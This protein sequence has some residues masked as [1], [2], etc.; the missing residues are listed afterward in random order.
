MSAK[1][2]SETGSDKTK[3]TK[4]LKW[5]ECLPQVSGNVPGTF[6]SRL[7]ES[8]NQLASQVIYIMAQVQKLGLEPGLTPKPVC[9]PLRLTTAVL[10]SQH[11]E[12]TGRGGRKV[13]ASK[14]TSEA[15]L[16][17]RHN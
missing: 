16:R 7:T 13:V 6:M 10:S 17:S 2:T 1:M 9:F 8:S 5:T 14:Q 12:G 15:Y 4:N 3:Q 11:A